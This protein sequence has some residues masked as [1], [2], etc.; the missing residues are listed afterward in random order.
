MSGMIIYIFFPSLALGKE[1]IAIDN[2]PLT[3]NSRLPGGFSIRQNPFRYSG[4]YFDSESALCYCKARYYSPDMMRF[5]NRDTYDVSNRYAY[6]GGNPVANVD[7]NGHA[8]RP[9]ESPA[10]GGVWKLSANE[11]A[12]PDLDE[13][14]PRTSLSISP[15]SPAASSSMSA[16]S[17]SSSSSSSSALTVWQCRSLEELP[18]LQPLNTQISELE[19]RIKYFESRYMDIREQREED[20][21]GFCCDIKV[22]ERQL[23]HREK[24]IG[25]LE[26][27]R[28]NS[29][30]RINR[31]TQANSMLSGENFRLTQENASLTQRLAKLEEI[32]ESREVGNQA[33][34]SRAKGMIGRLAAE[35]ARLGGMVQPAPPSP[36][37]SSAKVDEI[38]QLLG[39]P[40][41]GSSGR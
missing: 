22:L 14:S 7:L 3:T 16:S 18:G 26:G 5:M 41:N 13:K 21:K 2:G 10:G 30:I 20:I 38:K 32:I 36:P 34:M 11:L 6:C 25:D 4:Y 17:S 9:L 27:Q 1:S 28:E 12:E 33:V 8:P 39:L 29:D 15:R 31:L 24:R 19:G 23:R 40:G 35:N 37:P